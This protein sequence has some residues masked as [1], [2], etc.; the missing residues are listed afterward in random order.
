MILR[1]LEEN[2][3]YTGNNSNSWIDSESCIPRNSTNTKEGTGA[4]LKDS[5]RKRAVRLGSQDV[6]R[7]PN[8]SYRNTSIILF[9]DKKEI[10]IIIIIMPKT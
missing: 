5:E 9:C 7:S 6:K 3:R 10:I 8:L 2:L 4:R 1:G